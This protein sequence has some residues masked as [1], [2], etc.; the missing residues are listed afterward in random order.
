MDKLFFK[1]VRLGKT[2]EINPVYRNRW[3]D[4]ITPDP[5]PVWYVKGNN[6]IIGIESNKYIRGLKLGEA[7]IYLKWCNIPSMDTVTV[8]VGEWFQG[9]SVLTL[10]HPTIETDFT[11]TLFYE[12]IEGFLVGKYA[13]VLM[14]ERNWS[15]PDG[16]ESCYWQTRAGHPIQKVFRIADNQAM[17]FY[18]DYK[19][20]LNWD[21]TITVTA[22]NSDQSLRSIGI[23]KLLTKEINY[24]PDYLETCLRIPSMCP[25]WQQ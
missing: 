6:G 17:N 8:E 16:P 10:K 11:V 5:E 19:L 13:D 24:Y 12:L 3:D 15:C 21:S 14:C 1:T 2:A 9:N 4:K 7:R 20:E 23:V 22:L 25:Y 18:G